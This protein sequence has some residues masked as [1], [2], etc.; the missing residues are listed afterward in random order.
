LEYHLLQAR[1]LSGL[2]QK[3]TAERPWLQFG[4]GYAALW[5]SASAL[6]PP[7][8]AAWPR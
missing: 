2:F 5:G 8:W 6:Q 3:L 1:D 7:F 4:C